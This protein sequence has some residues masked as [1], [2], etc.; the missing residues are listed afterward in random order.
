MMME[1]RKP[2][3][4]DTWRLWE[5]SHCSLVACSTG[6]EDVWWSVVRGEL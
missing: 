3:E 2:E 4:P 5:L 6:T 1:A